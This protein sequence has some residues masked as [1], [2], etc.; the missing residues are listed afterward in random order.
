MKRSTIVLF[1]I[2]FFL[3]GCQKDDGTKPTFTPTQTTIMHMGTVT[4]LC[5]PYAYENHNFGAPTGSQMSQSYICGK[6]LTNGGC[7]VWIS[8]ISFI[9][10]HLPDPSEIDDQCNPPVEYY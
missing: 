3:A 6:S 9:P 7:L 2:A 8:K 5:V 1:S 10:T 4:H